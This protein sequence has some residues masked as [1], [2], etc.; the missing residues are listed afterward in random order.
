[1]QAFIMHHT[2]KHVDMYILNCG[3]PKNTEQKC[4]FRSRFQKGWDFENVM[5]YKQVCVI[6]YVHR[7]FKHLK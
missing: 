2:Q 7:T 4:T 5:L 3:T 6:I 1:M